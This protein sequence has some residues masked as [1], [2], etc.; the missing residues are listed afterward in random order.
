MT[1]TSTALEA[2]RLRL[3][4]LVNQVLFDNSQDLTKLLALAPFFETRVNE[5]IF[6]LPE[7]TQ[8]K[9]LTSVLYYGKMYPEWKGL[10]EDLLA[11]KMA[12]SNAA[13]PNVEPRTTVDKDVERQE[14]RA[15]QARKEQDRRA[16]RARKE[17]KRDMEKARVDERRV[18]A[19]NDKRR[20]EEV[21]NENKAKAKKEAKRVYEE[22]IAYVP[23]AK[24]TKLQIKNAYLKESYFYRDNGLF[25]VPTEGGRWMS[26]SQ[27][28]FEEGLF[29][30]AALPCGKDK[31]NGV[32]IAGAVRHEIEHSEKRMLDE[33]VHVNFREQGFMP[34]KKVGNRRVL[35]VA[36]NLVMHP[37][38]T[39]GI[40]GDKFPWIADFFDN[41]FGSRLDVKHQLELF[42]ATLRRCYLGALGN[43]PRLV[44]VIFLGGDE[45]CG[46]SCFGRTILAPIFG[47]SVANPIDYV[48]GIERWNDDLTRATLWLSSDPVVSPEEKGKSERMLKTIA[49][50]PVMT[51]STRFTT[52]HE[53]EQFCMK[54]FSLNLDP[55]SRSAMLTSGLQSKVQV[56]RVYEA[57]RNKMEFENSDEKAYRELPH[58]LAW[59]MMN[60]PA[61][62]TQV[63]D[64]RY[65]V[66]C[67]IHP[68]F[69]A[70]SVYSAQIQTVRELV[71]H[72]ID[73]W[74][75]GD[76]WKGTTTDFVEALNA[77][78]IISVNKLRIT[79]VGA[80]LSMIARNE[81]SLIKATVSNG[82]SRYEIT[83][84]DVPTAK[85]GLA[86]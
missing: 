20:R 11:P 56:Y 13:S 60:P 26:L 43:D 55:V 79:E 19:E 59:L 48:K 22:A 82:C 86:A 81:P 71:L 42:L 50:E 85:G 76:R 2:H 15:E 30:H 27:T 8:R 4:S 16:E 6:Y 32:S 84:L 7:E 63:P 65:G 69:Q 83:R 58:F 37:A 18:L 36:H 57:K 31:L 1:T 75:I 34:P 35:N 47:G 40:W 29:F 25:Y 10:I 44:P 17:T 46:K 45:G 70:E 64:P 23:P 49:S 78:R 3:A 52:R 66:P 33:V 53:I 72:F 61:A 54:I 14:R 28:K 77:V 12:S 39:V 41:F 68:E 21:F 24:W 80:G 5:R 38:A 67:E 62:W 73:G 51:C 9:T 74:D